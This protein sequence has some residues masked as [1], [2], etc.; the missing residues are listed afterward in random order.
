VDWKTR[1]V[2]SNGASDTCFLETLK[3]RER[4]LTSDK[5]HQADLHD[6]YYLGDDDRGD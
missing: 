1:S 4:K 5:Y 2:Y 3:K 6:V